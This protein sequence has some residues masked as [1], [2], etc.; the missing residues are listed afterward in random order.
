MWDDSIPDHLN[1][2]WEVLQQD[3]ELA[4]TLQLPRPYFKRK[5]FA[6]DKT[7]LHIFVDA[8]PKAYGT[9]AYLVNGGES[10]LILAKSRVAPLKELSVPKLELMAAVRCFGNTS[11]QAPQTHHPT[12]CR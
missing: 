10:V 1:R 7:P 5:H 2:D 3:L 6:V 8:S 11:V 12:W 9:V 4:T